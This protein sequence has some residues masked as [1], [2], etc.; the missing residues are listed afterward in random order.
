MSRYMD[1]HGLQDD[2]RRYF[3]WSGDASIRWLKHQTILKP[4]KNGKL[5]KLRRNRC[6]GDFTIIVNGKKERVTIHDPGPNWSSYFIYA[7]NLQ[8]V[9]R[10]FKEA[11]KEI[12]KIN[13]EKEKDILR[14]VLPEKTF[15]RIETTVFEFCK[16]IQAFG[17]P[18]GFGNVGIILTGP[19][20]T[21]KS[22]T[23]RWI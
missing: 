6:S 17:T 9:Y 11:G 1:E 4:V 5:I 12:H 23:M 7:D 3:T 22:E 15:N 8:G 21:G 16:A 20:G 18:K 13:R 2:P 14:P 19:P 10:L